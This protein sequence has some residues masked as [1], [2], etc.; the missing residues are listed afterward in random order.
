[1]SK[2]ITATHER[3]DAIPAIIAHLKKMRV[4]ECLD[5]H[6][7]TNGNWQGLSLGWTTVVWLAFLLSE[8]DH[9]LYRVE[10]WVKEHPRTLRRCIGIK[11][12]PRDLTDDRLATILDYL[13][14]AERWGACERA[15][16][17]SVLRVYDLQGRVVR[18][19]TTTAA[20]YVTP[21]GMFQLGHSKDHRPDLPQV[22]IA[23]AVL[24]PMGLPLTTTVVAGNSADDPLYLPE[25]AKV[26]QSIGHN[27]LTHIGDC[28]MA[29]LA[30]RAE[31]V[32][33]GDYYLCPLSALQMPA[34]ELDR[35][36]EPVFAGQQPLVDV[37]PLSGDDAAPT[38]EERI[39]VGF[40]TTLG[41]SG[42]DS[43][44]KTVRWEERRLVLRSLSF[45][46]RQEQSL[47]NRVKRA[48]ADIVELTQRKQ[49]KPRLQSV[50]HAQAA[51]QQVAEQHRVSE[52]LSI[53]VE[54][55][56]LERSKRAYGARSATTMHEDQI[57]VNATVNEP[58]LEQA[59]RRLGW[60]VYAS[61]QAAHELPLAKAVHAYREQYVIEQGFGRRKGFPLSLTPFYLHY[62]H[63]IVGLIL[64]LTIALRAM[65]LTQFVAREN[66]KERGQKL[67]GLYAGQPGRQTDRPT[68]EMMLRAFRGV[69]LSGFTIEG[70]T[71]WFL[72]SLS[73]TQ[74]R[75]LNLLGLSTRTFSTLIPAIRKT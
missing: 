9:R 5:T 14:V 38:P 64:L 25:I 47:R 29:A 43:S 70:E 51:A 30:T 40:E 72:T 1:M 17:E 44:G 37:Y 26:R 33:H 2:K 36:L 6:F 3:V 23:M 54:C 41:L 56:G 71:H 31:I 35:L 48:Q 45:A 53:E 58:A 28:K 46:K 27:G 7:P 49:G 73:D 60:R 8:G 65:V 18:V 42:Q 59:V 61:N 10:P 32:G 67:A 69:T 12:S 20:A 74:K 39:A 63:R 11:V 68:T 16:N 22:K 19:D 15:L 4:A 50:E 75:I 21:E 34:A 24:D 52:F 62:E 57:T 55:H 66:L 13:C